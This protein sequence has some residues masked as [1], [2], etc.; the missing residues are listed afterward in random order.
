MNIIKYT[1]RIDKTT[2]I[3]FFFFVSNFIIFLNQTYKDKCLI[4]FHL[5]INYFVPVRLEMLNYSFMQEKIIKL[6]IN[7]LFSFVMR[8]NFSLQTYFFFTFRLINLLKLWNETCNRWERHMN[9]YLSR[10]YTEILLL[11]TNISYVYII[12]FQIVS[13]VEIIISNIYFLMWNFKL[14]W[15]TKYINHRNV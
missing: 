8:S 1:F 15:V 14:F 7:N 3:H 12:I 4:F 6:Q 2:F 11:Y 5:N 13:F 10:Q 9:N